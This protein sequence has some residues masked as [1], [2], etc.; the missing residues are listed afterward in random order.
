MRM[1]WE[2]EPERNKNKVTR[3]EEEGFN[4]V[5]C[6]W[7]DISFFLFYYYPVQLPATVSSKTKGENARMLYK[8]CH[9][10]YRFPCPTSESGKVS[11]FRYC[12]LPLPR[13]FPFVMSPLMLPVSVCCVGFFVYGAQFLNLP[14]KRTIITIK[15]CNVSCAVVLQRKPVLILMDSFVFLVSCANAIPAK[16]LICRQNVDL[17][18]K[19]GFKNYFAEY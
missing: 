9:L 13:T 5:W 1:C 16:N 2:S 8:C 11:G 3:N 15:R 18:R 17:C 7:V 12:F 10:F 6:Q 14:C 4:P 19:N